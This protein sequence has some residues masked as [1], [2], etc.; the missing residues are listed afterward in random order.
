MKKSP[1]FLALP[2]ANF[3]S[4]LCQRWVTEIA[5]LCL[6]AALSPLHRALFHTHSPV[7]PTA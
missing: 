6:E 1:L 3:T 2:P 7:L 4:P 5:V